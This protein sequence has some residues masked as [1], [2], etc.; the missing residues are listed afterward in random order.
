MKTDGYCITSQPLTYWNMLFS[1]RPPLE[2]K[3]G[4][5]DLE[6]REERYLILPNWGF[7]WIEHWV[8]FN[9]HD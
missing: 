8:H 3:I 5:F 2:G 1:L 4:R 7:R 6:P 9:A